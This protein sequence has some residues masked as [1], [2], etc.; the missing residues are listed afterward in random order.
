M[1]SLERP[2][3]AI[4][5]AQLIVAPHTP[6]C[7]RSPKAAAAKLP[8]PPS[9]V[10]DKSLA[11]MAALA[12]PE[13]PPGRQGLSWKAAALRRLL[14]SRP[15]RGWRKAEYG[16]LEPEISAAILEVFCNA[17]LERDPVRSEIDRCGSLVSA[18][19]FILS[20]LRKVIQ[21]AAIV[22]TW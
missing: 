1:Q 20:S 14:R 3:N 16:N 11:K 5:G 17:L 10:F 6:L 8:R 12:P 22:C 13:P 9:L 7:R 2:N 4:E 15:V 19:W 21:I 18:A